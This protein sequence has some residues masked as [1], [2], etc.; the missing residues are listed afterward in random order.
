MADL[1]TTINEWVETATRLVEEGTKNAKRFVDAEREKNKIRSEIG[2]NKK[3]LVKAYEQF[4]R[5]VYGQIEKG[6]EMKNR[7]E[8]VDLIRSKEKLI[9]LLQAKLNL[10]EQQE[11]QMME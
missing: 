7:D 5:D 11:K 1:N 3:E 10:L 6:I 4:G 9:S 8:M 2:M